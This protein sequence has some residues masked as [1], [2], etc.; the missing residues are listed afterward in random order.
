MTKTIYSLAQSHVFCVYVLQQSICY[1]EGGWFCMSEGRV[2]SR[3]KSPIMR[4]FPKKKQRIMT[5]FHSFPLE[6]ILH[7]LPIWL[8]VT[9][10][11]PTPSMLFPALWSQKL[12][13][14]SHSSLQP[15]S[16]LGVSRGMGTKNL[17][18]FSRST[19]FV[20]SF[21]LIVHVSVSFDASNDAQ[22]KF[23]FKK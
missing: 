23:F 12:A 17:F 20:S 15:L 1:W 8:I 6:E 16:K 18:V 9:Q 5:V 2:F 13:M 7:K 4:D 10:R 19:E 22:I 21:S 3:S 11:N 14:Q